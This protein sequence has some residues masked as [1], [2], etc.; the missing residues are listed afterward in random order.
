MQFTCFIFSSIFAAISVRSRVSYHSFISDSI[1]L[2]AFF[3]LT[4]EFHL[5][6]K[7]VFEMNALGNKELLYCSVIIVLMQLT[8]LKFKPLNDLFEINPITFLETVY[9]FLYSSSVLIIMDSA[10][11]LIR[12]L[13]Y[14][15]R[16]LIKLK[17]QNIAPPEGSDTRKDQQLVSG[18]MTNSGNDP[19][20]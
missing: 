4:S 12:M 16:H 18:Q 14:L 3:S 8:I 5:Q 2:G 17:G 20:K 13:H 9:M 19:V 10:K 11:L 6:V 1:L 15:R 7:T